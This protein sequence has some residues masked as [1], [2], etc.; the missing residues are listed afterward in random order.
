VESVNPARKEPFHLMTVPQCALAA[1]PILFQD[2]VQTVA[3]PVM[4]DLLKWTMYHAISA[5]LEPATLS[6][7][8]NA[9]LALQDCINLYQENRTVSTAPLG[10]S[11]HLKAK[12]VACSV[13]LTLCSH[14]RDRRHAPHARKGRLKGMQTLAF[15]ILLSYPVLLELLKVPAWANAHLVQL[16]PLCK[17]KAAKPARQEPFLSKAPQ[18][19]P[20]VALVPFQHLVQTLVLDARTALLKWTMCLARYAL[21]ELAKLAISMNAFLVLPD[22]SNLN[23]GKLSV[24]NVPVD[25]SNH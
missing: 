2:L 5:P 14:W 7:S 25:L 24:L 11:N 6:K 1:T 16:D 13:L 23:Q 10:V 15:P 19:A 21:Q 9:F 20:L 18:C 3:L 12:P 17:L 4:M 22:C 8:V